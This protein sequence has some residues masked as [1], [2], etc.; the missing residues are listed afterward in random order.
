MPGVTISLNRDRCSFFQTK[1][2]F[3]GFQL[4]SE[5]YC[6]D[7]SIT[8][9]VSSFPT[10]GSRSDL[11]SFFGLANQLSSSTDTVSKLLLPMRTLLSTKHDFIWSQEHD[12]AFAEAKAKLTEVP[13]LA[14]FNVAKETRLCT[15]A[16]RQGLGFVLQQLSDNGHWNLV[17][18]GSRF[19]TS[20]ESR[21]AVIE[22]ELLAI[23]WAVTKCHVFLGGMQHFQVVTDHSPLI[24]ILN[25]H[26][27]DEIENP[28]L[29]RLRTR[30][31]AYNF[32]A[33]WCK[34]STHMAPDALSRHPIQEPRQEDSLAEYGEDHNPLLTIAE[35]R[36]HQTTAADNLRLTE[37]RRQASHDEEYTQ[38]KA[39]ILEGFPSHRGEL[40][41][42]CRRYW[43]VRHNLTV[44]DGL[45]VEI[46]NQK[47]FFTFFKFFGM[48]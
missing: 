27:L 30:L 4:S 7:S 14:Y 34:G 39:R 17:Q 41:E 24:P 23:A 32:T 21:Y 22:L 1:V 46:S 26:R 42:T 8:S 10:P 20:A 5:G 9:A 12:Q 36:T 29:Q 33:I 25:S 45:V 48:A 47:N 13:T 44:E 40:P 6:V 19:L 38:L 31:M 3:A 35:I 2:T 18:A 28:R 43:Q 15:D 37:L 11:R 16:S